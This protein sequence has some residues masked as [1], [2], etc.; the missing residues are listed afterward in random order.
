MALALHRYETPFVFL[1]RFGS[2]LYCVD[3]VKHGSL[4]QNRRILAG[5]DTEPH[6]VSS[7]RLNAV[8]A[9]TVTEVLFSAE[10]LEDLLI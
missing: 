8:S 5:E 1:E 3:E 9:H 10:R 6:P 2:D 4:Q 7:T